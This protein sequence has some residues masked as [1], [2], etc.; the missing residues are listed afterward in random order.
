MAEGS[1]GNIRSIYVEWALRD[2]VSGPAERIDRRLGLTR[3]RA[4]EVSLSFWNTSSAME[5]LSSAGAFFGNIEQDLRETAIR[6][7]YHNRLLGE[8]A[9]KYTRLKTSARE[10]AETTKAKIQEASAAINEHQGAILG[11]GAALTGAGYL[12]Y[13]YYAAGT[14][15]LGNYEDA[16]ATFVKNVGADSQELI[17]QMQEASAGTVSETQI[18]LNAN[19]AM[20]MDIPYDYLPR[21]ME[22]SRASARAMGQDINYMF[23]SI[24]TGSARESPLILDNLGIQMN[25]LTEYEKEWAKARGFNANALTAEQ[26]R[27]VFLNYV[28][29]NSAAILQK[30]DLSQESLNE[31]TARSQVAWEEFR[32]ELTAGARPAI[33]GILDI[34][35]GATSAL[36]DM[37]A[38]LKAVIGTA[39]L[40][41]T[42][43]AGIGGPMLINAVAVAYLITNYDSLA[44]SLATARASIALH[45]STLL[46]RLI[47]ASVATAYAQGGLTA[48]LWAGA[49]ASWAFLAPWLPIIGAVGLAVGAVLLLQDVLV[50]GW[51]NSYLGQFVGWLLEKLPFLQP[52]AAA[53]AGGFQWFRDAVV[54]AASGVSTFLDQ[55]GP[56][57]Y[58]ILGPVM[59]LLLLKDLL[60]GTGDTAGTFLKDLAAIPGALQAFIADP[61]GTITGLVDTF[62]TGI[63]SL[64]QKAASA[65]QGATQLPVIGPAIGMLLDGARAV[66]GFIDR[67]GPLKYLILGPVGAL[68]YL[69]KNFDTVTATVRGFIDWIAA[70]PRTLGSAAAAVTD[71]PIFRILSGAASFAANPFGTA[72]ELITPKV[73]P[74]VIAPDMDP[75]Y[76]TKG[77][78][79]FKVRTPEVRPD[80]LPPE[81]SALD[82]LGSLL[83]GAL[84]API[85]PILPAVALPTLAM[86]ALAPEVPV[87][88]APRIPDLVAPRVPDITPPEIPII[89]APATPGQ[90][91]RTANVTITIQNTVEVHGAADGNLEKQ[92]RDALSRSTA[93]QVKLVERRLVDQLRAFGI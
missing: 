91:P 43:I 62:I 67:L 22:V 56:L 80:I 29:E 71:N 46:T 53:V 39:G 66:S 79:A 8:A 26:Q 72:L 24:V 44:R 64:P 10:F 49:A 9:V 89:E 5:S 54:G 13:N 30:V 42:V 70:I 3:N 51:D 20:V 15:D 57:K 78:I 47:P 76:Y 2:K 75:E 19:R 31:Q 59:P 86:Q 90:S 74:E 52:V 68:I 81:P 1:S 92:I 7:Q 77:S 32:R 87:I 36:R 83:A 11:I 65:L 35:E 21:M 25:Q 23:D 40:V 6:Q 84:A 27:Q 88:T 28:M 18:I 63:A 50:K 37:P 16:Y 60:T 73:K 69:A 34:T 17:R 12:G 58:L 41:G 61:I 38:P 85:T 48:A 4:E 45:A 14:K 82:R 33:A 55:L 93:D